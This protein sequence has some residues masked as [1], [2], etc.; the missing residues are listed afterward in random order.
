MS[1]EENNEKF[2]SPEDEGYDINHPQNLTKPEFISD[3]DKRDSGGLPQPENLNQEND[4]EDQL[5]AD[6]TSNKAG[7][8]TKNDESL[9]GTADD[10]DLGNDRD[11]EDPEDDKLIKK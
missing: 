9:T 6:E 5:H 7:M 1:N 2:K 4:E 10:S 3:T 11:D 8:D